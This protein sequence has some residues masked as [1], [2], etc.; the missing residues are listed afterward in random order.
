MEMDAQLANVL[1]AM[2]GSL[3]GGEAHLRPRL[4][5]GLDTPFGRY[6]EIGLALRAAFEQPDRREA[7]IARLR[8]HRSL[9]IGGVPAGIQR[10]GML[11]ALTAQERQA[12]GHR[13]LDD[14]SDQELAQWIIDDGRL[15]Y[16]EFK[17]D[18][19]ERYF[20]AVAP[21][22]KPGSA[23]I[24]LGSGLGKV[25]LSAALLSA[26]GSSLS[27]PLSFS[28]CTGVELLPYRHAMAQQRLAAMVD[29][30]NQALAALPPEVRQA[31]A[32]RAQAVIERIRLLQ[33]DMFEADVSGA[34]LVFMYSTCFAPLMARIGDKLARDLPQGCLVSTTTFQLLHPGYRLVQVFPAQTVAW[35][36]VYLYE[37]AGELGEL[38]PTPPPTLYEPEEAAWE[39][40]VRDAMAAAGS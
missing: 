2:Q 5:P 21:Y 27:L 28:H 15:I 18:E 6:V 3:E 12:H 26:P 10:H 8:P 33:G 14:I 13:R 39:A 34:G 23:M 40:M 9:I 31:V 30:G 32:P 7:C 25:V 19:L 16:G 11:P 24:D 35:T 1:A 22:L 4:E 37:R 38:P 29:A 20:A 17:P 36:T